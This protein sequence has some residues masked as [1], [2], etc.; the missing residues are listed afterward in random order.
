[1]AKTGSQEKTPQT[2]PKGVTAG[3]SGKPPDQLLPFVIHID[4]A[5][6]QAAAVNLKATASPL[7]NAS[8]GDLGRATEVS[9]PDKFPLTVLVQPF[10]S[11][12]LLAIDPTSVCF[13]RSDA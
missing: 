9:G 8:L 2:P 12:D 10:A 3:S 7:A 5:A 4:E 6:A 13:F 1:M 11:G